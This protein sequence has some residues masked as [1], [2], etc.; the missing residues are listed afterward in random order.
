[1]AKFATRLCPAAST[2]AQDH[3]TKVSVVLAKSVYR[4][5]A[6]VDRWKKSCSAPIVVTRRKAIERTPFRVTSLSW[7][8]GRACSSAEI[9]ASVSL[10]VRCT[11]ARRNATRKRHKHHIARG[12]QMLLHTAHVGRHHWSRSQTRPERHA[13]TTF[14]AVHNLAERHFRVVIYASRSV[15]LE[16]VAIASRTSSFSVDVV[17]HLRSRSAIKAKPKRLSVCVSAECH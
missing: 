17:A 5:S 4:R 9:S 1:V 8:A 14:P 16:L 6:T 10:T 2:H 12:R 3:V 15:I 7:K 13:R 11:S